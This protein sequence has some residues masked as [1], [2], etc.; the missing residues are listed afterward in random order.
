MAA[1]GK[2]ALYS[3]DFDRFGWC[4]N[5]N[6][7]VQRDLHPDLICDA[8]ED[9]IS[10]AGEFGAKGCKVNGAGGDGGSLTILTDG[11]MAQ[12]RRLMSVL[13]KKNFHPLPIYLSRQG[14]RVWS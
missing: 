13:A 12:K 11:D 3:G 5:Q 6:T 8:F 2:A 9:I 1:E 14:L 7:E 10:T 4:M